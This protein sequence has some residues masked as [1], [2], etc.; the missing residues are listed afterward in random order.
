MR[1]QSGKGSARFP[2]RLNGVFR[3]KVGSGTCLD[4]VPW[5][6][7]TLHEEARLKVA[8]NKFSRKSPIP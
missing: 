1:E 2:S 3:L 7:V 5:I 8:Q 4:C 6:T